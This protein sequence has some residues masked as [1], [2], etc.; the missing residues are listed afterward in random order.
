MPRNAAFV[1][2]VSAD[3]L[4]TG[5]G[6]KQW[7]AI[8]EEIREIAGTAR[9]ISDTVETSQDSS[10]YLTEDR[11]AEIADRRS[12]QRLHYRCPIR[13]AP[14]TK[15]KFG[16]GKMRDVSSGGMAFT[17]RISENY[18]QPD[19]EIITRFSVPRF[20]QDGSFDTISMARMGHIRRVDKIESSLYYVA[21]QFAQ[22]LTFKPAEQSYCDITAAE[23][24]KALIC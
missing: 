18:L 13:Y 24:K 6:E 1:T 15:E 8:V 12:E 14:N 16:S 9:L 10:K 21:M 4:E 22:P 23:N 3:Q 11:Q 19:R 5:F 7:K 2:H 17:C 20:N